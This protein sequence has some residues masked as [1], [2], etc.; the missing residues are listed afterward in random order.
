MT[1][2]KFKDPIVAKIIEQ[3]GVENI[4]KEIV[5]YIK[6]K[7]SKK[8]E[9]LELSPALDKELKA[10]KSTNK[11]RAQKLKKTREELSSLLDPNKTALT[12]DKVKEQY[13]NS[14]N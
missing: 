3:E 10:L 7:F 6:E 12:L 13:F 14:K 2:I 5:E 8:N 9:T 1:T 11:K 4:T